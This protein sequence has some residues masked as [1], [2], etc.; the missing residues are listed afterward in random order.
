MSA[1]LRDSLG[2]AASY[3]FV[4]GFIGIATVLMRRRVLAPA[5]TRKVIHIGVAHWWLIAMALMDDPWVASVGPASFIIINALAIRFRLLPA[6]DEGADARNLGTVY[7]PVALLILVNLCWRGVV[8]VWVGGLA[9]LVLGWGDG[10]AAIVG[11]KWGSRKVDLQRDQI[12]GLRRT[13]RTGTGTPE[14]YSRTAFG[15]SASSRTPVPWRGRIRL[16]GL[17]R[18]TVAGTAAMFGAS[19][20]VSL[21]FTVIFNSRFGTPAAAAGVSVLT[22]AAA[23]VVE[24]LTPLGVD[25]ITVPLATALLYAGV[26]A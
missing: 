10:L 26:F 3:V 11:E 2:I 17:G 25:N 24:V 23:T 7:F 8:P 1:A 21:C 15:P 22:A 19:F 12:H 4:F 20:T 14:R 9:V 13:R 16:R 6:M 5:V 18:K